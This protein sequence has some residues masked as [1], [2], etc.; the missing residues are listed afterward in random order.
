MS[1]E[2]PNLEVV[3]ATWN[4]ASHLHELLLSIRAQSLKPTRL[5]VRDDGS[6]DH[7]REI[8]KESANRWPGWLIELP[9]KSRL[10]SNGNFEA[11]LSES[12]APFVA[13]A[14][15]DDRWDPN[16][17]KILMDTMLAATA[18]HPAHTPL[19]VY[20]DLRLIDAEGLPLGPSFLHYQ[21]LNPRRNSPNA[22]SLQ[23]VVT[24][25]A[26][27]INRSLIEMA[28]PLPEQVVQHDHWL[29]LI[30]ACK[31][32]VLFIDQP[33]LSYRLHEA[34]AVGAIGT[35]RAYFL[36]RLQSW[37]REHGPRQRLRNCLH[38]AQ[39][40]N[41]RFGE[42]DLAITQFQAGTPLERLF[43][44]ATGKLHKSGFTRQLALLI[45]LLRSLIS[46]L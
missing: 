25:C 39:A 23:N 16:K 40:L 18:L 27:L 17:L 45:L 19:L 37:G 41:K 46:G 9:A 36:E 24:G 3:L 15:Q 1:A 10:G 31:G 44:I 29:A 4:G 11:L 14:D 42:Q 2:V 21:R 26:S 35:G 30:A 7:T 12:R 22:L 8:I 38:Q 43:V 28:L 13:L 32:Q 6:T 5:L 34:N 33:L 20:S